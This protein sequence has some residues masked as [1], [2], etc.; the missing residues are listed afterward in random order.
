MTQSPWHKTLRSSLRALSHWLWPPTPEQAEQNYQ[1]RLAQELQIRQQLM[2]NLCR[3][4]ER[5]RDRLEQLQ[6]HELQLADQIQIHVKLGNEEETQRSARALD[7]VRKTQ[8]RLRERLQRAEKK[9]QQAQFR[10]Q[11]LK[12]ERVSDLPVERS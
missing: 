8:N 12:Q 9:Y 11:K 2:I 5:W 10:F 7:R 3:R 4:I 1:A 6:R